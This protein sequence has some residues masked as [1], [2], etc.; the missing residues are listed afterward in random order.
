MEPR[1]TST[2]LPRGQR[3]SAV[4]QPSEKRSTPKGVA[5]VRS[6]V[7]VPARSPFPESSG[8]SPSAH[9]AVRVAAGVGLRRSSPVGSD[10]GPR[11]RRPLLGPVELGHEQ[12]GHGDVREPGQHRPA[13][14]RHPSD[15]ARSDAHRR[16][17]RA[18]TADMD[19]AYGDAVLRVGAPLPFADFA[20]GSLAPGVYYSTTAMGFT[21]GGTL[22]L[23][24]GGD[25]DA[26][27]IMQIGGALSIGASTQVQLVGGATPA[28]SSGRST[29]RRR[30]ARPRGS[31]AR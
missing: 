26:V 22:T 24:A 29:A 28:T 19:L 9:G 21:A 11:R 17:R 16:R 14:R 25:Q 15:R 23:D 20:A 2:E 12:R 1:T 7:V 8:R 18:A 6:A 4:L 31:P 30:S 3:R 10:G 13:G 27:F 5:D